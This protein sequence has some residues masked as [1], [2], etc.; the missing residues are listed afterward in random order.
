MDFPSY[1]NA[2]QF[3][4][5]G[6]S[7]ERDTLETPL[8]TRDVFT[9][10]MKFALA[11][12]FI[13]F[14]AGALRTLGIT[15]KISAFQDRT[16]GS[17]WVR[18]L[19]SPQNIVGRTT[20][21]TILQDIIE[22]LDPVR[23]KEIRELTSAALKEA[24]TKPLS[25][26]RNALLRTPYDRSKLTKRPYDFLFGTKEEFEEF[27]RQHVFGFLEKRLIFPSDYHTTLR[28]II[29][30]EA[31]RAK[32]HEFDKILKKNILYYTKG[33]GKEYLDNLVKRMYKIK[34]S[35]SEEGISAYELL[36]TRPLSKN[37]VYMGLPEW[38]RPP[39]FIMRL[40][41]AAGSASIRLPWKL[42]VATGGHWKFRESNAMYA[43]FMRSLEE[44]AGK[45]AASLSAESHQLVKSYVMRYVNR[46]GYGRLMK[47]GAG[48]HVLPS[49]IGWAA[50]GVA[51]NAI[52]IP[53]GIARRIESVMR[54][55]FGRELMMNSRMATERQRAVAAIQDAQL[56]ARY[57]LGNE[58][59]LYH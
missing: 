1:I 58:A 16:R 2:L 54:P 41:G 35:V 56:N 23:R 38:M 8:S 4:D 45:N 55:D 6:D 46:I 20:G 44:I 26:V 18:T 49:L 40:R 13:R 5:Y 33:E 48:L 36:S 32:Y 24:R 37:S 9:G 39:R 43:A 22:S 57:L 27:S 47:L 3:Y 59:S 29:P 42:R 28:S 31:Y 21:L 50:V 53:T 10:Y 12:N 7:V 19:L 11:A 15:S 34:T 52:S 17:F 25:F 51:R 30:E 14:G